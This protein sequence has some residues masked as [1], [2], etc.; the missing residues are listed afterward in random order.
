MRPH[1]VWK[2]QGALNKLA[3]LIKD[4]G[5]LCR[6]I[7]YTIKRESVVLTG[8]LMKPRMERRLISLALKRRAVSEQLTVRTTLSLLIVYSA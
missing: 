1:K 4:L 5:V 3:N 8:I 2:I 7:E 6:W